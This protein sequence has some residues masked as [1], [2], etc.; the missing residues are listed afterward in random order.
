MPDSLI[1]PL[2]P[3]F[4]ET[5]RFD[6]LWLKILMIAVA[7]VQLGF[8]VVAVY[9]QFYRGI[10]F[11]GKPLPDGPL[12]I[13][14]VLMLLIGVLLPLLILAVKLEVRLDPLQLRLRLWPFAD[15]TL[16]LADIVSW[17]V[18]DYRPLRDFGG[19]GM[20]YSFKLKAWAYNARGS[21]GVFLELKDGKKIMVGSQRADQLAQ[22]LASSKG[23]GRHFSL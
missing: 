7:T 3:V 11:G 18:R 5:Q 2:P 10:P 12:L 20:H 17:Q 13:T 6:Q 4:E 1:G 15:K 19:W 23:S 14:L 8:I 9:T 22:A 16:P 21:R